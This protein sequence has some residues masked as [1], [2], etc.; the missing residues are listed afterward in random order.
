MA[1]NPVI[2]E[3]V[4]ALARLPQTDTPAGTLTAHQWST[5]RFLAQAN[6]FSRTV[7]GVASY[8]ATT[9]GTAS[10]LVKGLETKG[11]LARTP[12]RR[13]R[14]SARLDLTEQGLNVLEHDPLRPLN[15]AAAT[16]P[17]GERTALA[18][19]LRRLLVDVV[20]RQNVGFAGRCG[21]CVH[22]QRPQPPVDDIPLRCGLTGEGLM[23]AERGQLCVNFR[24]RD[25]AD[26]NET[27]TGHPV[28]ETSKTSA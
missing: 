23:E 10:Q 5:L 6:R 7:S 14:R 27:A 11:L 26:A 13:D 24:F 25:G 16:L 20:D 28:T 8:Q 15:E 3:M 2:A 19:I 17:E 1:Q 12:D 9:R 18:A 21:E 4:S 22:L